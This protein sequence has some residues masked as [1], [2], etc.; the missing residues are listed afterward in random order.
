MKVPFRI[1]VAAA[2]RQFV[3]SAGFSFHFHFHFDSGIALASFSVRGSVFGAR[4][5][6]WGRIRFDSWLAFVDKVIALA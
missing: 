3:T 4:S 5:S 2:L 1:E 6:D